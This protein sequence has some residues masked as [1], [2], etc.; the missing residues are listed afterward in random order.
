MPTPKSNYHHGDLR[1]SLLMNATDIIKE[2][3]VEALSMRRLADR[4]GVSRT[5]PY[6]HFKD[7]NELLCAIAELGFLQQEQSIQNIPS[8]LTSQ[9]GMLLFEKYVLAY[10]QFADQHPETYDLMFGKEIW[11]I[12][13][14]TERLKEVSKASFRQWMSWVEE[15]QQQAVL[16]DT[17]S[18]LRVAQTCWATLHGLCRLMND[19][20]YLDR[21]DLEEMGRTAVSMLISKHINS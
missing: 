9:N 11:K 7:K 5:A 13:E 1:Q 6:H 2:G 12:G 20:I 14:P 3:G 4:T 21:K 8:E 16:P 19:G 10:I 17:E 15:L 18:S